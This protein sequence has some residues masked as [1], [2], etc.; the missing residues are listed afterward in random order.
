LNKKVGIIGYSDFSRLIARELSPYCEVMIAS[1]RNIDEETEFKIVTSEEALSCEVIIPAIPSQFLE[2]YFTKNAVLVNY[3]ALIVDVCSVKVRPLE[4]LE[5]V[6]PKSCSILA[7]HPMFG[8]FSAK[9]G[10]SGLQIMVHP[11]RIGKQYYKDITVFLSEKL[12]LEVIECSPEEHDKELAYVLGLTQLIG[13]VSQDMDIPETKLRTRAYEDLLD[14]KRVQ[15]SDSWDLF[16]SI[17][18]ENPYAEEV[19]KNFTESIN[20]IKN[21]IY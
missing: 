5:R 19:I 12:G 14:M 9:N 7:T 3:Q 13:K 16:E 15:G 6:L 10:I 21:R 1:R 2:E 17:T 8:P 4:T 20:N 18:Q 11:A